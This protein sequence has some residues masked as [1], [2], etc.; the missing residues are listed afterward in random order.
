MHPDD[1]R[2]LDQNMTAVQSMWNKKLRRVEQVDLDSIKLIFD[3]GEYLVFTA[4]L[5]RELGVYSSTIGR[6]Q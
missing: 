2:Q 1:Q 6:T 4:Y 5:D 3:D